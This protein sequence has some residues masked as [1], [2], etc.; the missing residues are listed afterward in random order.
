MASGI[1]NITLGTFSLLMC[2]CFTVSLL[3]TYWNEK[4]S[5]ATFSQG[6]YE[7]RGLFKFCVGGSQ[8]D[9]TRCQKI[10]PNLSIGQ[11]PKWLVYN[12]FTMVIA[13]IFTFL[14]TITSFSGHPCL[15]RF[16]EAN[17]PTLN[18]ITGIVLMLS[19]VM[20]L[21]GT[22]WAVNACQ[23]N[24]VTLKGEGMG[25]I[26]IPDRVGLMA[27]TVGWSLILGMIASILC[28]LVCGYAFKKY[29]DAKAE[30]SE[31]K[32]DLEYNEGRQFVGSNVRTDYV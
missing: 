15:S 2:A 31:P 10:N 20:T 29:F 27:Y 7:H 8:N 12:Q 28:L 24:Y 13:A 1:S 22:S 21:V 5:A 25:G 6:T 4:S 32:M 9:N 19:G 14:A 30:A 17:R 11:Q 18:M 23:K 16:T 3:T 26:G